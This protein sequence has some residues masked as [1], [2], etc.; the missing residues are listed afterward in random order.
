MIIENYQQEGKK[1]HN[2]LTQFLNNF[3]K[4]SLQVKVMK[5]LDEMKNGLKL[6]KRE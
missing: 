4:E 6:L 1:V 2:H 5:N 3:H